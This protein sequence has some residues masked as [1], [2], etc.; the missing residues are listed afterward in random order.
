MISGRR[1]SCRWC[2]LQKTCDMT[3]LLCWSWEAT[4]CRKL[5]L[6]RLMLYYW[7]HNEINSFNIEFNET[8]G[9]KM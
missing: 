1:R 6:P 3:G 5:E 2:V 4:S 7:C 9:R 8:K